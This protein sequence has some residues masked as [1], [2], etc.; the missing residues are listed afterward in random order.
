MED[1]K[2]FEI[3]AGE[4]GIRISQVEKT[5]ALLDDGNTVP[6]IARY[7][8][9]ATGELD[10]VKIRLVEERLKF[11]R[12]LNARKDEVIRLIEEQGKLTGELRDRIM[13]ATRVTEVEDLYRPYRQKRKTRAS[14]AREKGL[15][16]LARYLL[17]FPRTGDL[18]EEAAKYIDPEKGVGTSEEALQGARDIVAEEVSDDPDVRGW[19][20]EYTLKNGNLAVSARNKESSS[21]YEMYYEFREPVRQVAPHRVL[22]INRGERE[23][24][25]RVNIEADEDRIIEYIARKWI[26]N[27]SVTSETV[28]AAIRDSYRRLIAPAVERDVRNG[29]TEKAEEQAVVIFSKNLRQLLM[30]PPVKGKMV[31]GVDP[32]YRTGCKWAVV[33]ETGKLLDV[34]VVY[35]TPPQNRVEEARQVFTRLADSYRIDIITIGNGTASRETEQ[36]T[37]SFIS[38]YKKKEIKY[39]IVSEAGASVYS[40]SELAAREFPELDVSGRSAVS[41]ARRLQDPLAELVKIEPRAVG[42]GQYQHDIAPKRLEESLAVVVESVVN[43]VGCDLNTASAPLLSYISGVNT[44]VA[45]NIVKFREDTGKFKDRRQLKKVPRLGPKTF[46]QCVGFLR[47]P[48]SKNPLDGTSI[49][50]ESYE[51]AEKVLELA[52]SSLSEVGTLQ[53]RRKLEGVNPEEAAASLGAGVPTVRDILESLKRPGLDPREDLQGPLFRSD[54]LSLED[55]RPGMELKGTVRNVVDFGAFV[56]IGVKVDGLVHLSQLSDK[57]VKHPLDVV[58]VGEVVTVRVLDVDTRRQRVSLTMKLIHS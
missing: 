46:E 17:S 56:D 8:K 45:E 13:K 35:P 48:E 33:D 6:F 55:L 43:Y 4:A 42:V 22:A 21:V 32:A 47:L 9:E 24:I 1:G 58:S 38:G 5:V 41:I 54:V 53:L 25:L 19:V 26:K 40:A 7:R 37:A 31:L 50:P 12:N 39:I 14:V 10:E 49:H 29:L 15:D 3:I 57:Y 51:L 18:Q 20:R 23:E 16:P 11:Y 34:G 52:G 27:S 44:S 30:Q 28:M 36:F 2:L